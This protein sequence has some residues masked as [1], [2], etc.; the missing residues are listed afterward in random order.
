MI[1]PTNTKVKATPTEVQPPVYPFFCEAWKEKRPDGNCDPIPDN[2]NCKKCQVNLY[3]KNQPGR[4]TGTKKPAKPVTIKDDTRLRQ[5]KKERL[6]WEYMKRS[7]K[8]RAYY[9]YWITGTTES[10]FSTEFETEAL[11]NHH[12]VLEYFG[13]KSFEEWWEK[14]GKFRSE[15]INSTKVENLLESLPHIINFAWN[16]IAGGKGRKVTIDTLVK[17]L[18]RLLY[19][20]PSVVN[21]LLKIEMRHGT[22]KETR[23]ILKE[24][25]DRLKKLTRKTRFMEDE[26]KRYLQVFDLRQSG[27]KFRDIFP[28]VHLKI[29]YTE[30]QRRALQEDH[31]KAKRIIKNLEEGEFFWWSLGGD[32]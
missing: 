2:A 14:S 10:K 4:T 27:L 5:M 18:D 17:T 28:K 25:K 13:S 12:Q 32:N 1:K 22:P 23:D 11:K 16:R 26:L 30:E 8:F 15:D 3:R 21:L 20:N 29:Q 24:I 7:E 19:P 31:K 9:D 6:R